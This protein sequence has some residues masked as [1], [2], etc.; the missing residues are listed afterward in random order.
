MRPKN[1]TMW[2]SQKSDFAY[3]NLYEICISLLL[4]IFCYISYAVIIIFCYISYEIILFSS[5]G[6]VLHLLLQ[7]LSSSHSRDCR[8]IR[9]YIA[10]PSI[11]RDEDQVVMA[12]RGSVLHLTCAG[13]QIPETR[14]CPSRRVARSSG[15]CSKL[16]LYFYYNNRHMNCLSNPSLLTCM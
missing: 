11:C 1:R 16:C 5:P 4:N 3:Q 13:I 14:F 10:T 15:C 6:G 8:V 2:P 7:T 9:A 12:T